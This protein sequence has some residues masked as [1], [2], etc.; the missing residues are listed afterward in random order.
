MFVATLGKIPRFFWF[1]L[2]PSSSSS[3]PSPD[4]RLALLA[5]PVAPGD[6]AGVRT[7]YLCQ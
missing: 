6:Q 4:P 3:V 7:W 2:L 5:S 1:F